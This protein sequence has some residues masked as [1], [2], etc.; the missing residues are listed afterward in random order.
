MPHLPLGPL[1]HGDEGHHGALNADETAT[2]EPQPPGMDS[3][4]V[5]PCALLLL[6][7]REARTPAGFWSLSR[8]RL[9]H[10]GACSTLLRT[11]FNIWGGAWSHE[12]RREGE[13]QYLA[14]GWR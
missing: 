6:V 11:R 1:Q 9:P 3:G 8:V 14:S 10:H 2:R 13:R 12:T 4:R 7:V 5:T